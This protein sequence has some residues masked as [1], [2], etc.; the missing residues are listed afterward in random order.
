MQGS[1]TCLNFSHIFHIFLIL[2]QRSEPFVAQVWLAELV[3]ALDSVLK[4]LRSNPGGGKLLL[5]S[6]GLVFHNTRGVLPPNYS[7]WGLLNQVL[8]CDCGWRA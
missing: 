7:Q 4:V 1:E 6:F 5:V 2:C 8:V 3:V